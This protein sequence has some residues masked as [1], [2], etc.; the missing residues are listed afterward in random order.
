LVL[1]QNNNQIEAIPLSEL[2]LNNIIKPKSK[3][4]IQLKISQN[5]VLP[6][7]PLVF[8]TTTKENY[9]GELFHIK[10]TDFLK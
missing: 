6:E 2:I 5:N 7:A 9:L 1:S 4:N 8:Y 10:I 3:E